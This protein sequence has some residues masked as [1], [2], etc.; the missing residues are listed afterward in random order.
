MVKY[1][2]RQVDS[3][4]MRVKKKNL[5]KAVD[6]IAE[7]KYVDEKVDPPI[8]DEEDIEFFLEIEK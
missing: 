4:Y 5:Q 8:F 1:V 6:K 3:I 2:Y 7:I